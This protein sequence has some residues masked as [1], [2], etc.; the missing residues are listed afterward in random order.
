VTKIY[1]NPDARCGGGYSPAFSFSHLRFFYFTVTSHYLK[2]SLLISRSGMEQGAQQLSMNPP[3]Q[4]AL[5]YVFVPPAPVR[6]S[7]D[8]WRSQKQFIVW[9]YSK[10]SHAAM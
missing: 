2:L 5:S 1:I 9:R 10:R 7:Q 8:P 3:C 6:G 4:F